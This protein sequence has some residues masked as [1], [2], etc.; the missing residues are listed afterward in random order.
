MGTT[1]PVYVVTLHLSNSSLLNPNLFPLLNIGANIV[2]RK[3]KII[4]PIQNAR[5]IIDTLFFWLIQSLL[6][7]FG[8]TLG[9]GNQ[10]RSEVF[11][12]HQSQCQAVSKCW[13]V[14]R[15]K[16]ACNVATAS[17]VLFVC[18]HLIPVGTSRP[19]LAWELRMS[20]NRTER[21]HA[22]CLQ[23]QAPKTQGTPLGPSVPR[24]ASSRVAAASFNQDLTNH[25]GDA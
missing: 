6:L 21:R 4:I 15:R 3:L 14:S 24:V 12:L 2:S 23:G 18:F 11:A 22:R 25:F 16:L 10:V 8:W 1:S 19:R 13:P 17:L 5:A 9:W 7:F 20:Y